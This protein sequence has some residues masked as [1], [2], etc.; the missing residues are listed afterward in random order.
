MERYHLV[1]TLLLLAIPIY[2]YTEGRG[3]GGWVRN[4]GM[5]KDEGKWEGRQQ[6][7][8]CG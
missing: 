2:I 5:K 3:G 6:V 8:K 1:L 4:V 7:N